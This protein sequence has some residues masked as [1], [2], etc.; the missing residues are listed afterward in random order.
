MTYAVG[1]LEESACNRSIVNGRISK[2]SVLPTCVLTFIAQSIGY[3]VAV[4]RVG[5]SSRG[6]E[7]VCVAY[8]RLSPPK[9]RQGQ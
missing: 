6:L 8:S 9:S 1:N 5:S 2:L 3:D 4:V 7:T